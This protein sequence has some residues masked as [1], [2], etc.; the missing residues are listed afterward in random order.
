M[1]KRAIDIARRQIS[2][3]VHLVEQFRTRTFRPAKRHHIYFSFVRQT[4]GWYCRFHL[5]DLVKTPISRRF[6]FRD[7][8][9]IHAIVRRGHGLS[10]AETSET[11]DQAIAA[12]YGG[13]WLSLSEKQYEAL[14]AC[15]H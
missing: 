15:G 14:I 13:I 9:K 7:P 10:Q 11:L 12:G 4:G 2:S 1:N 6:S 5:D 8:R 3:Y